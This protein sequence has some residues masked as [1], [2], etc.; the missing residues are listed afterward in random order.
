MTYK[1][2]IYEWIDSP[3]PNNRFRIAEIYYCVDGWRTRLTERSFTTLDEAREF[4]KAAS[5]PR[6]AVPAKH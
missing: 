2:L 4:V 6:N 3:W 1:L 5:E